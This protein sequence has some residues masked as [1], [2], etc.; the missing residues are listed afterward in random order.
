MKLRL[1]SAALAASALLATPAFAQSAD[2]TS[3]NFTGLRAGVTAST[4]G[5]NVVDF[6]G[7]TVGVELG[8]DID[9]GGAVAGIGVEYQ[10]GIAG[11]FI[12]GNETA[13]TARVGAKVGGNALVYATGALTRFTSGDLPFDGDGHDSAY[14]L[15]GGVEFGLGNGGTTLKVEQRYTDTG[16]GV[17]GFQTLVG[18]GFRF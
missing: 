5:N 8:Y 16:G 1:L 9:L 14:R 11:D 10:N 7:Q 6:D 4:G 17:D 2:A 15:G 3:T 12:Q 18:L 13:V